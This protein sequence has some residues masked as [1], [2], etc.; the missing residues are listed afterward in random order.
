[1][2]S[3]YQG[4][5]AGVVGNRVAMLG[6]S[7]TGSL[8]NVSATT[9][10][11]YSM[12]STA[13]LANAMF[14]DERILV[15]GAFGTSGNTSAQI[16]ARVTDVTGLSPK[17]DW[18]VVLAGTNDAG[19]TVSA[20]TYATNMAAIHQQLRAVGIRAVFCV[21]PPQPNTS[22]GGGLTRRLLVNRYNAW[23]RYYTFRNGIPLVDFL[24]TV[25]EP[26]DGGWLA[27][28]DSGDQIHPNTAGYVVIGQ[29]IAEAIGPLMQPWAP[30]FPGHAVAAD[31]ANL[32]P[33][34]L[35]LVDTNADGVP[36]S[37]AKGGT[38]TSSVVASPG[39][40]VIGTA[41]RM[42]TI[43]TSFTQVTA[44]LAASVWAAGDRLSMCVR[45]KNNGSVAGGN[46]GVT[47][48]G[49]G[50]TTFRIASTIPVVTGWQT[51]YGEIVVPSGTTTG[52]VYLNANGSSGIDVQI[53][54]V[55]V[56]NLTAMG[57]A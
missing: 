57:V 45:F 27:A 3:F 47:F 6:D 39:D 33:G 4:G 54:Q 41:L 32:V 52:N 2:A 34:A 21:V 19:T 43:D 40:P 36:D 29:A 20:A 24:P 7:L 56:Y 12:G 26:T 17:P 11:S 30:P 15:S 53:A 28:Y 49:A 8:A 37:W 10:A 44:N 55:A 48:T 9:A 50:S 13:P 23:L 35:F 1:V 31:T 22:L 46:V 25:M 38:H 5:A 42:E 14:A 16:L 18:C 51:A